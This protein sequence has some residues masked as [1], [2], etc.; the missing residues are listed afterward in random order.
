M[1]SRGEVA[2]AEWGS[3]TTQLCLPLCVGLRSFPGVPFHLGC[4]FDAEPR[5]IPMCYGLG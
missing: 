5:A 2:G 1:L 4:H 3:L